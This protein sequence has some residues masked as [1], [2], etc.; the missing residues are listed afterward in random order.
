MRMRRKGDFMKKSLLEFMKESLSEIAVK[1]LLGLLA[2]MGKEV[3]LS[4]GEEAAGVFVIPWECSRFSIY[5]QS[6]SKDILIFTSVKENHVLVRGW[7]HAN[8]IP[9]RVSRKGARI[10]LSVANLEPTESLQALFR[11]RT[12]NALVTG[13]A[14]PPGSSTLQHEA[15]PAV[16][17]ESNPFVLR[18]NSL[19]SAGRFPSV[20]TPDEDCQR[21]VKLACRAM[22]IAMMDR[23]RRREGALLWITR[24]LDGTIT[25]EAS[26][27]STEHPSVTN[28]LEQEPGTGEIAVILANAEVPWDRSSVC[29]G[30]VGFWEGMLSFH[31]P[32]VE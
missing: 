12:A 17:P 1:R 29:D 32:A 13:A 25:A 9:A 24:F 30:R 20:D 21:F 11:L 22:S 15:Q 27:M 2:D 19:D 3:D 5:R 4:I 28:Q 31:K 14:A 7:M 8:Q 16:D 10:K 18:F 26:D 23:L 6:I